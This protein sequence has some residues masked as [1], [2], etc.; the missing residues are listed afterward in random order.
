MLT[1]RCACKA[2][3]YAVE[4]EFTV[5]YNC[6]CSNCR[7][8]TGSAFLPWGEIAPDKLRLTGAP[9]ARFVDGDAEGTHA[10]R[11]GRCWSLLYWTVHHHGR[12]WLRVPFG[13]LNEAPTLRPLGHIFVGS[14]ADWHEIRDEL[15]QYEQY[16]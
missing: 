13:T 1:G 6:H 16:P 8:L 14:K 11:C 12:T 4:D 9:E 3:G 2:L 5:A 10:M 7:A 15:P